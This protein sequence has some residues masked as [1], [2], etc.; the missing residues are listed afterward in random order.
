VRALAIAL[1][2][3]LLPATAGA[4]A[5]DQMEPVPS[6]WRGFSFV[7]SYDFPKRPVADRH[8]WDG[9]SYRQD[10]KR[11]LA[12]VLTYVLEG[13]DRQSWRVQDNKVRHWYH[14]PWM[15]LGP[16][17]R[18]FIHGLTR[19]RDFQPGALGAAQTKC[20]QNWAI[21][22]FNPTGA[23]TLGRIWQPALRRKAPDLSHLP[24][25]AGT[26]VAKFVFT[27]A[28]ADDALL[29]IGAPELRADIHAR[30]NAADVACPDATTARRAPQQLRLIQVDLAIKEARADYKTGWV[31]ASFVYDGRKAG[32]DPWAKLEPVGLM[33]GNDPFLTDADAASGKKPLES[34]VFT[35]LGLGHAFGRGGRMNGLVDEGNSAC[36]SCHMAAQWPTAAH[37][38]PQPDWAE[39]KCWFRN[40]DARY[41]FGLEPGANHKCADL[42]P[43][44]AMV[45]L[46]FSLQLAI[47]LRNWSLAHTTAGGVHRTALGRLKREG[48][49]LTVNEVPSVE[50]RR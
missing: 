18:E 37:M 9:I 50:L 32:N 6:N 47:A 22:F 34:L 19:E 14:M 3:L 8:P 2:L 43:T 17:G 38:T 35:D 15:G 28:A 4:G 30:A 12:T 29:L 20:R 44:S 7:P 11:Y 41:P 27:E 5:L 45:P 48:N 36:S 39:A 40:L 13:Q 24:F 23:Y 49:S 33:W 1:I 16:T 42:P 21:A 26:V 10:P 46:D 25:E 31:F